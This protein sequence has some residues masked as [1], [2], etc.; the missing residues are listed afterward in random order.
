MNMSL[1]DYF[2]MGKKSEI[3]YERK[4]R[5]RLGAPKKPVKPSPVSPAGIV[6]GLG[7]LYQIVLPHCGM[8]LRFCGT[9]KKVVGVIRMDMKMLL[10]RFYGNTAE[11][12]EY[13]RF[14]ELARAGKK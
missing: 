8:L 10:K 13:R 3:E 12:E 9:I 4:K 2:E 11:W 1:K 5:I 7:V 14:E 6:M